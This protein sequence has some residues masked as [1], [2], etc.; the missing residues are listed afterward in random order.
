MLRTLLAIVLGLAACVATTM[1]VEAVGRHLFPPPSGL[2]PFNPAHLPA[3][4]AAM[5]T[6]AFAFIAAAWVAGA[7]VGGLVIGAVAPRANRF[8]AVLPGLLIALGTL[9]MVRQVP[10]PAW[11][12]WIGWVVAPLA[13]FYAGAW[14]RRLRT[15]KAPDLTWRGGDR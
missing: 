3:I 4:M 6:A 2:D 10:H 14:G 12:P 13:A 15:P 8:V 5:P 11:M 7:A 9:M 1:G